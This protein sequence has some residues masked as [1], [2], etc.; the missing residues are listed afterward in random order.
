MVER[1]NGM[2]VVVRGMEMP[3]R[4]YTCPMN[5]SVHN[6]P[7][8]WCCNL[9]GDDVTHTEEFVERPSWCPLFEIKDWRDV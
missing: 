9:T 4:C 8:E 6:K 5:V 2:S 1:G 7:Y 3:K